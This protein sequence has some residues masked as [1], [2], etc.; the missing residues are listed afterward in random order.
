MKLILKSSH[1]QLGCSEGLGD[2]LQLKEVV[3]EGAWN[4]ARIKGLSQ[5]EH[6][7]RLGTPGPPS[8][9][10]FIFFPFPISRPW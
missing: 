4:N 9:S 7:L 10:F 1:A 6:I 5:R 3:Q 8:L 2:C